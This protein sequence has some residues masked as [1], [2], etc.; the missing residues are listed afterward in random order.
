MAENLHRRIMIVEDEQ[1]V[2]QDLAV[3]VEHLGY[4]VAAVL[5]N[6]REALETARKER[7]DLALLDIVLPGDMDGIE[8]ASKLRNDHNL[9]IVYLTAYA[10]RET[11][12]RAKQTEPHGYILKP[13][14]EREIQTAIEIALY[15]G[16]ME[17]KLR[18]QQALLEEKLDELEAT[19][20]ELA[21][22]NKQLASS[23]QKLEFE[24]RRYQELFD[25]AP[26]G[27]IVTDLEGIIRDANSTICRMSRQSWDLMIH[28]PLPNLFAEA[29]RDKL[30][31]VMDQFRHGFTNKVESSE[32]VL[33]LR[34][35]EEQCHCTLTINSVSDPE[36]DTIG[37][38]W[39]V[40]DI[41]ERKRV[42]EAL[43]QSE[44]WFRTTLYSI[45][46]AVITIDPEGTVLQMNDSAESLTGWTESEAL[47]K[48]V[49]EIF[50]IMP[51][52]S[53]VP[54]ENPALQALAQDRTIHTADHVLLIS[55]NGVQHPIAATAS[56]VHDVQ[57]KA[58]GAVLVFDD[59]SQRRDLQSRLLQARKMDAVGR[60]A[61][62]IA[63]DFNNMVSVILGLATRIRQGLNVW[64]P[65]HRD[66]SSIL[67]AA[68]RSAT[69]TKKLLTLAS[70]QFVTQVPVN[71][72]DAL[73]A[74]RPLLSGMIGENITLILQPG[75]D[76]WNIKIDPTQLDQMVTNLV[77]NA[78]DAIAE[79]GTITI[80]T[81][82]SVVDTDFPA[83]HPEIPPGEYVAFVFS[84]TGK[85][86][87]RNVR[88]NIFEPFF[89]TKPSGQGTGL[90]LATVFGIVK[91]NNGFIFVESAPDHGTT[92]EIFLPRSRETGDDRQEPTEADSPGGSETILL[93][94]DEKLLL[95]IIKDELENLGYTVLAADSPEEAIVMC[96]RH[97]DQ[98][99]ILVTDVIMPG[100]NGKE[101]SQ[102]LRSMQP[103]LRVIFMSG[104]TADV[105]AER[106]IIED[107]YHFLQKPFSPVELARKVRHVLDQSA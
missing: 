105:V 81:R 20:L 6:G 106:G 107:G 83:G 11:I 41:S 57:G 84:D 58:T 25:F 94:E 3:M 88:Q 22:Q 70:R 31:R 102:Q 104:H 77:A 53:Q 97:K 59:Q 82:N 9:P 5:D 63:H 1:I 18:T 93:V 26:D 95:M 73:K 74:M 62:G 7:P 27:Y 69:L 56:P 38:R 47:Q 16:G 39:L 87:D 19:R 30:L 61:G 43:R 76:L 34:G 36:G 46:D 14:E 17:D 8:V 10:D 48:N 33:L 13:F 29:D 44:E 96:E 90:G 40:H 103:D 98:L 24:R 101:L 78:R 50:S 71:L 32:A 92:F 100:M 68:Q 65:L 55:R 35:R 2:A 15:K 4:S 85:G 72:N 75:A 89:T 99:D 86:M 28:T 64:D 12:Q 37:L 23:Q 21:Q 80:T 52:D 66:V 42:E 45:G 51:E 91:Q 79:K 60:L 54:V 49:S 67:E